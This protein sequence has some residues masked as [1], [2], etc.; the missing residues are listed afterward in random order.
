M[1]Y[2][3]SILIFIGSTIASIFIIFDRIAINIVL[4]LSGAIF[5]SVICF[6]CNNRIKLI[7][8]ESNRKVI[9]K[10]F[11]YLCIPK[12][13]LILD[14]ENT[15][16]HIEKKIKRNEND[17]SESFRLFIINDYKNLVGIDLI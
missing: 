3:F 2:F 6:S 9:I 10:V 1:V 8:D 5:S 12:M 15:H 16:F 14:T 11:N 13:K 7:K 4:F 17:F